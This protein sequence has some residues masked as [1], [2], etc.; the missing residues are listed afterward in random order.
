M[1]L[2]TITVQDF[3]DYFTRDFAY[4]PVW[5]VAA[6]Y[7]TGAIVYYEVTK[8]FYKAKNDG[9]TSV[10]TTAADWDSYSDSVDNYVLDSDVTK[11]FAQAKIKFNQALFDTD[12]DIEMGYLW[13]TAHYM[14]I[15]LQAALQGVASS[16]GSFNVSSRSVGSVSESYDIPEVYKKSPFVSFLAKTAYGEKYFSLIQSRL[17][18]NTFVVGGGTR[19]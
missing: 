15:D 9:V 8:L 13:L 5:D 11:A 7:N 2:S 10:P 14:V 12:A 4:L 3:K 16:G 17:V 6:S 19:P 18:G 1:D